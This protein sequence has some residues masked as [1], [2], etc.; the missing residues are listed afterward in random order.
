LQ[1]RPL[2]LAVGQQ[3][4]WV[5][6]GDGTLARVDATT[7]KATFV[8]IAPALRDVTVA[9]KKIWVSTGAGSGGADA[10]TATSVAAAGRLQALPTSFC[11]PIQSA[12]GSRPR[13]LIVGDFVLQGVGGS[14]G[15][16][17]GEAMQ[18]VLKQHHY[19]AGRYPLGYQF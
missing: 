11:S 8:P 18:F 9:G 6:D 5:A 7:D 19:R 15:A 3:A 4:A 13:F 14:I 2:H 16:Q 17:A 12:S 1:R 10:A